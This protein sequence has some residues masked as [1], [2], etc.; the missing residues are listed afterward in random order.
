VPEVQT[1]RVNTIKDSR[2]ECLIP[3]QSLS[4][5]LVQAKPALVRVRKSKLAVSSVEPPLS[6][7]TIDFSNT[8]RFMK[9]RPVSKKAQLSNE[10]E[11]MIKVKK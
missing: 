5:E 4:P 3:C 6:C 10:E 7:R 1:S 2:D 11:C 9:E 8:K